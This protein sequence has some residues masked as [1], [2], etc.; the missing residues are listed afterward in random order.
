MLG[1]LGFVVEG[2][3]WLIWVMIYMEVVFS[4]KECYELTEGGFDLAR[5]EIFVMR[6]I[7]EECGAGR[8]AT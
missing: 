6:G 8:L 2:K 5:V 3:G 1:G 4:V 7:W